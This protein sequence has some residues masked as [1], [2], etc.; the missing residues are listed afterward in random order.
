[1]P[2]KVAGIAGEP[3]RTDGGQAEEQQI[4]QA[5]GT[6]R[7]EHPQVQEGYD[8]AHDRQL[9]EACPD[10]NGDRN[11]SF[12][13]YEPTLSF[14]RRSSAP[15]RAGFSRN[16]TPTAD[17]RPRVFGRC[18]AV[19]SATDVRRRGTCGFGLATLECGGYRAPGGFFLGF[20]VHW[21]VPVEVKFQ[22]GWGSRRAEAP[23]GT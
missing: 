15:V 14:P 8:E 6:R 1:L 4:S 21:G 18:P 10:T 23:C 17:T 12:D 3:R 7:A 20:A 16:P 9:K 22:V 11:A 5:T 13:G 19:P 2:D